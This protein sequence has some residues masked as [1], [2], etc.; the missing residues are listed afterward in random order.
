[1]DGYFNG[2]ENPCIVS[3]VTLFSRPVLG[4][5]GWMAASSSRRTIAGVSNTSNGVSRHQ[6]LLRCLPALLR[7]GK[8]R[9][10]NRRRSSRGQ[11]TF[12][13]PPTMNGSVARFERRFDR[14]EGPCRSPDESVQGSPVPGRS[15]PAGRPVVPPVSTESIKT[16]RCSANLRAVN[17]D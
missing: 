11:G 2:R 12:S 15:H 9:R 4:E 8:F 1:M 6:L 14:V 16:G 13:R 10:R 5:P 7:L 17:R 3:A